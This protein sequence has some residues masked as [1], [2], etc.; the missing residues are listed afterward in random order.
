M[1]APAEPTF[2]AVQSAPSPSPTDSTTGRR[3]RCPSAAPAASPSAST[4]PSSRLS[5]RCPFLLDRARR[6]GQVAS[7]RHHGLLVVAVD[8]DG[9]MSGEGD[10]TID[11]SGS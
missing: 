3:T 4:C 1:G 2:T 10:Y 6:P 7:V 11:S 8:G 9:L 5:T